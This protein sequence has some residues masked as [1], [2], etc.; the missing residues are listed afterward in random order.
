VVEKQHTYNAN[1]IIKSKKGEE[2]EYTR[3]VES[4]LFLGKGRRLPNVKRKDVGEQ[5]KKKKGEAAKDFR[6]F[7]ASPFH[8]DNTWVEWGKR[9]KKEKEIQLGYYTTA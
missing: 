2:E 3:V 5:R 4:I 8:W 7:C 6:D 9:K 1:I